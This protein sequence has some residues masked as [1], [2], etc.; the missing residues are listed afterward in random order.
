MFYRRKV[1]LSLLQA[2]GG[3]SQKTRLQKLLFLLTQKQSIPTYEF[4]P[5]KFG[6]FSYS[7][8]ADLS[9]LCAQNVVTEKQSQWE[10]GGNSFLNELKPEDAKLVVHIAN[11][12]K[13]FS[14]H[15]LITHTYKLYPYFAIH[16]EIKEKHLNNSELAIV[17]NAI[18]TSSD[19]TLFTIGYEGISFEGYLN[20][21]IQ[22]NIKVLVDVRKNPLSMKYGFSKNQLSHACEALQ[23]K[24]V[25]IPEVGIESS[26]RKKLDSYEDYQQ[27]FKK[28]CRDE[29]SKSIK[30]QKTIIQ[31]LKDNKH[32]ALTCF[33]HDKE[34]CHRS[35]LAAKLAS[36]AHI[37]NVVHL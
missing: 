18:P 2:I 10:Y 22:N 36:T 24:Y 4:V 6:S 17:K 30:Q 26:K 1:L 28:Y 7:A 23:I 8:N 12:Y 5:Y 27:L 15:Q 20:K 33:E 31:L 16:S 35:H 19:T 34:Y 14:N 3:S 21:L 32:I 11:T 25:H 13:S 9:A 29:L 37:L